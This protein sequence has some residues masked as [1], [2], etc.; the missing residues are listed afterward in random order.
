MFDQ[1][2]PIFH[3]LLPEVAQD[4]DDVHVIDSGA[5]GQDVH[6]DEAL[7]GEECL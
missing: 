4:L 2:S 3:S 6:V 7:V 5:A 1:H